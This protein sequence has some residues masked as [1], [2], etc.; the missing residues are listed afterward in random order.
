MDFP[1]CG[2]SGEKVIPVMVL[3][4]VD[5]AEIFLL[6]VLQMIGYYINLLQFDQ[7]SPTPLFPPDLVRLKAFPL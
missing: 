6:L 2:G 5:E 4:S 3:M 1:F 7:I